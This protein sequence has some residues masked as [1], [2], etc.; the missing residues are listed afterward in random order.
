LH[1]LVAKE[2][3]ASDKCATAAKQYGDNDADDETSVAFLFGFFTW[4]NG[5]FI[6]NFFSL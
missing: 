1:D 6:H 5:H 2:P 3:A 4:G